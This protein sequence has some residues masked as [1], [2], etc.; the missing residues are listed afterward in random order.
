MMSRAGIAVRASVSSLIWGL[1]FGLTALS[2]TAQA[3]GKVAAS[4]PSGLHLSVC[5][6]G[7]RGLFR[8]GRAGGCRA[9]CRVAKSA[10][11]PSLSTRRPARPGRI[12]NG[13]ME[14]VNGYL[15]ALGDSDRVRLFAIDVK[16][17]PMMDDFA[18]PRSD[19][20][21]KAY[22]SL[23]TRTPLGATDIVGGL[24]TVLSSLTLGAKAAVVYIGDGMSAARLAGFSE[25]AELSGELRSR[26]IA[27]HSFAV[28]PQIDLEMLGTLAQQTG[29]IVLMDG[30]ANKSAS[31][32]GGAEL[33]AAVHSPVAYPERVSVDKPAATSGEIQVAP[34]VALPLRADRATIYLGI[35]HASEQLS[36]TFQFAPESKA[37]PIKYSFQNAEVR[38][39]NAVLPYLWKRSQTSGG[40]VSSLA[41]TKLLVAAEDEFADRI[42]AMVGDAERAVASRDVATGEQLGRAVRTLDPTNTRAAAV[43]VAA[44]KIRKDSAAHEILRQ[45]APEGPSNDASQTPPPTPPVPAFQG[46]GGAQVPLEQRVGPPRENPVARYQQIDD[47][48]RTAVDAG[49]HERGCRSPAQRKR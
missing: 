2:A 1:S 26:H 19:E 12:A 30:R 37:T 35:G 32:V 18:S 5:H 28:G 13:T 7:R 20:C 46:P 25:M 8:S 39:A 34:T 22:Q 42:D 6:S 21:Q 29:G 36:L 40:F 47:R 3:A 41:G 4:D 17:D 9:G 15:A 44:E 49:G 48:S 38:V 23:A 10:R 14:I 33:V 11:M 31:P 43:L 27:V 24:R 45:V 16:A